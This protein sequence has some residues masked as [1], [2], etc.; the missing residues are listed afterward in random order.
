VNGSKN[1]LPHAVFSSVLRFLGYFC[2][3]AASSAAS[4]PQDSGVTAMVL[5]ELRQLRGVTVFERGQIQLLPHE[6]VR[7]DSEA[8]RR[9]LSR[10]LAADILLLVDPKRN[11]FGFIDAQTGEELFRIRE[12]TSEHLA[13]SAFA[14]VEE[15][16]DVQTVRQTA[17]IVLEDPGFS[18]AGIFNIRRGYLTDFSNHSNK[19]FGPPA[20]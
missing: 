17:V 12:D 15:Q 6:L 20:R 3:A 19:A 8:G 10:A 5:A 1:L 11:A 7:T 13:M 4:L 18:E 16:R 14:L 9:A 2:L